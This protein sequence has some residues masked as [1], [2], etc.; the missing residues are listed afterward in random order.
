MFNLLKDQVFHFE[1]CEIT[2]TNIHG[3]LN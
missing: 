2:P 3:S 1:P